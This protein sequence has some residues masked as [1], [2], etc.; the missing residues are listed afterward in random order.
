[1][2]KN[3]CRRAT[4]YLDLQY[5]QNFVFILV[6]LVDLRSLFRFDWKMREGLRGYSLFFIPR[7]VAHSSS[8]DLNGFFSLSLSFSLFLT[9]IF[10]LVS[11]NLVSRIPWNQATNNHSE[12]EFRNGRQRNCM[13]KS[14]FFCPPT[15]P[16][17]KKKKKQKKKIY[18][19]HHV[20]KSLSTDWMRLFV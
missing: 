7:L 14:K 20:R 2:T 5:L 11:R 13:D 1:M 4:W 15:H 3:N 12:A 9:L 17:K 16:K 6:E 19:C 18:I 10:V 8:P